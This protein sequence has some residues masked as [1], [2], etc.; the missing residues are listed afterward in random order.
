MTKVKD[1]VIWLFFLLK[2]G[3]STFPS[4]GSCY[5]QLGNKV[6]AERPYKEKIGIHFSGMIH[7][8]FSISFFVFLIH[9]PGDDSTQ[10]N[11]GS[12]V[13]HTQ[14]MVQHLPTWGLDDPHGI[15]FCVWQNIGVTSKLC[16]VSFGICKLE[17]CLSSFPVAIYKVQMFI[18]LKVIQVKN[19][20]RMS[21]LM[22]GNMMEG[23]TW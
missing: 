12:C 1:S 18:F 14:M 2:H 8:F 11:L 9:I 16:R 22:H 6:L 15:E 19:S 13:S 23:I 17:N 10:S 3:Q 21:H 7:K 4:L 5:L 20:K